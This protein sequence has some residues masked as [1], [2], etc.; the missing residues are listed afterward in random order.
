MI[1]HDQLFLLLILWALLLFG[2]RIVLMKLVFDELEGLEILR[3][4]D[5]LRKCIKQV[6]LQIGVATL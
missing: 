5:L 1:E 2:Q 6:G 3:I 4:L